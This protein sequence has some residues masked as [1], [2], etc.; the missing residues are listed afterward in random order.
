MNFEQLKSEKELAWEAKKEEVDH[1]V[2]GLGLGIDEKIKEPVTS[3]LAHEFPTNAS[4]EGHIAEENEGRG[5]PY[6]WVEIYA[7]EPDGWEKSEEKQQEWTAENLKQRA[8]MSDFLDEFYSQAENPDE[9]QLT[10]EDKGIYGA[11][12]LRSFGADA[13]ESLDI[14]ARKKKLELYRAEMNNFSQFMKKK[15]FTE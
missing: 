1:I 15:Y 11:F 9:A 3:L 12:R 4:C 6:P 10:L 2:D 13:A 7:P 14:E 8:R 5:L